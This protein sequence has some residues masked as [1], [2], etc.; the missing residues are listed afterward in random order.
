[1]CVCVFMPL[2]TSLNLSLA[3]IDLSVAADVGLTPF[4]THQLAVYLPGFQQRHGSEQSG[5][6]KN[7]AT[8][9]CFNFRWCERSHTRFKKD[10]AFFFFLQLIFK[11]HLNCVLIVLLT[12]FWNLCDLPFQFQ[13][14]HDH[15]LLSNSQHCIICISPSKNNDLK[16]Q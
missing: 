16:I 12:L 8:S 14:Y 6:K 13:I 15:I 9:L 11:T 5:E 4:Q 1:M 2:T 10:S 7:P 3:V